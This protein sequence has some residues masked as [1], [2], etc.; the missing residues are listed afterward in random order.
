MQV[1]SGSGGGRFVRALAFGIGAMLLSAGAWYA[2]L[3][4]T[5]SE[6]GILAILVG[7]FIGAAVRRGAE[8]RG[9]WRYQTL[10][11]ALTY[12]AIVFSYTPFVLKG[13]AEAQAPKS[14]AA[15]SPPADTTRPAAT[16]TSS[17]ADHSAPSAGQVVLGLALIAAVLFAAP[18]V[19]GFSNPIGLIII[20][21]GLYEAWKLNKR[22]IIQ[23]GGPFRVGA[24]RAG[25]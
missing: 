13:I 12:T 2:V 3:K 6:F 18:I 21:I 9:G 16:P 24:A 15:I 14:G 4:L 22:L 23:I 5:D 25:A 17:T 7:L 8:R 20:A 10:A 1:M 11:M 19:S